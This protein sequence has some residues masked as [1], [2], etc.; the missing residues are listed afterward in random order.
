[1]SNSTEY[2]V[3]VSVELKPLIP[4]FM[5]SRKLD[6]DK[7]ISALGRKDLGTIAGI[8][9]KIKG[10]AGSFGFDDF[11]RLAQ[12]LEREVKTENYPKME[13]LI[14][15][16]KEYINTAKIAYIEEQKSA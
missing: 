15:T 13:V 8:A 7:L 16:M 14:T 9:H 10:N 12:A 5:K 6:I 3:T 4:K 2:V 11:G 1:M